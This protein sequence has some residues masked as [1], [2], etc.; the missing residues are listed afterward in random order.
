MWPTNQPVGNTEY[1]LFEQVVNGG[2]STASATA[3]WCLSTGLGPPYL[4]KLS[5]NHAVWIL[6]VQQEGK[7]FMI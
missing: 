7:K 3:P 4:T 6:I 1:G 5:I 2:R